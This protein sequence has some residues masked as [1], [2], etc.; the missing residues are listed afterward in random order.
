VK[1]LLETV[2]K[3]ERADLEAWETALRVAVL[4]CGAKVLE[5]MLAGQGSGRR[6]EE[7][8]GNGL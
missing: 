6:E 2:A 4:S 7:E 5:T 8:E 1:R 3:S